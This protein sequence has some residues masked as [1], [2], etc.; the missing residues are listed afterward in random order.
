VV[1]HEED[2]D[3]RALFLPTDH[4]RVDEVKGKLILK[5]HEG[6]YTG[7]D[8]AKFLEEFQI[9]DVV[10]AMGNLTPLGI[11]LWGYTHARHKKVRAMKGVSPCPVTKTVDLDQ[12]LKDLP[13]QLTLWE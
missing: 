10:L 9:C 11:W 4:G 2:A 12:W 7:E 5:G 1:H 3:M 8:K 13:T 6:V